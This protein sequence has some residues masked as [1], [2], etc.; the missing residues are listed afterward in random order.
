MASSGV[1]F[2]LVAAGK[3]VQQR[4]TRVI[5]SYQ[6]PVGRLAD[7]RKIVVL[8]GQSVPPIVRLCLIVPGTR[9]SSSC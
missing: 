3:D 8:P 7:S 5:L 9:P 4:S 2:A 1:L 6:M